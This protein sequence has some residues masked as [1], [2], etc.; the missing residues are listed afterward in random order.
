MGPR[1]AHKMGE[2]TVK[3]TGQIRHGIA[4]TEAGQAR[5]AEVESLRK[6][7]Q[8]NLRVALAYEASWAF[9]AHGNQLSTASDLLEFRREWYEWTKVIDAL[10]TAVALGA[11]GQFHGMPDVTS[12]VPMPTSPLVRMS[13]RELSRDA[14]NGTLGSACDRIDT[15]LRNAPVDHYFI[16]VLLSCLWGGARTLQSFCDEV[17]DPDFDLDP[18]PVLDLPFVLTEI[19]PAERALR[20][21]HWAVAALLLTRDYP[22]HWEDILNVA[23]AAMPVS[24]HEFWTIHELALVTHEEFDPLDEDDPRDLDDV[25][26]GRRYQFWHMSLD[27]V[28]KTATGVPTPIVDQM[29]AAPN[30]RDALDVG[31]SAA[32]ERFEELKVEYPDIVPAL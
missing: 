19:E 20:M 23:R 31:A 32:C 2:M 21:A 13:L 1:G 10:A 12:T 4:S 14:R 28:T 26:R 7:L 25:I 5:G 30:W 22:D 27:L 24:D 29:V 6:C 3:V 17:A 18:G 16:L 11:L 8:A 9:F 15:E